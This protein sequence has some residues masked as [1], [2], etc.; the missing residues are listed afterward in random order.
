MGYTHVG[1]GDLH[2]L[3]ATD[4]LSFYL[5][6]AQSLGTLWDCPL[7]AKKMGHKKRWWSSN[8]YLLPLSLTIL[9][10]NK[11]TMHS[12]DFIETHLQ[13]KTNRIRNH[14]GVL[15]PGIPKWDL[16]N[17]VLVNQISLIFLQ[18]PS[19]LFFSF[20]ELHS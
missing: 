15:L 4:I 3:R 1:S 18:L 6:Q 10:Q 16:S 12:D 9:N 14:C 20:T 5:F 17:P 8:S 11:L 19:N 7:L 13:F 2:S